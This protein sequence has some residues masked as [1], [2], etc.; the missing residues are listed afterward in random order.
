MDANIFR[1]RLEFLVR[2]KYPVL[3]LNE[4]VERLRLNTLPD[5]A[6]VIT[7]DDGFYSTWKLAIPILNKM[8]LP[9]TIYV[10]TYYCEKRM[11]VFRLVIQYMFWKTNAPSLNVT[12]LG[13][14]KH[15]ECELS[16]YD[17][18]QDVMWSIITFGENHMDAE[19]Q[20]TLCREIGRQLGIDYDEIVERRLFSVMTC[21]ELSEA[22]QMGVDIQLHT[23]RHR[24]PDN[25]E[26]IIKELG[27][28][29]R[30]LE[31]VAGRRLRHFCYPSGI[32][33][34]TQF[35][36]LEEADVISATTCELGLN[37]PGTSLL[38]LR[39]I[40]DANNIADVDFEAEMSGFKDVLRFLMR[41]VSITTASR[42]CGALS[43]FVYPEHK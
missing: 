25:R 2:N 16:E 23:H 20:A 28:N 32:Y 8:R 21:E 38:K 7:F 30:V 34:S 43:S 15:G 17:A 24:L 4:A 14:I 18:V 29:R 9:G 19:G 33:R 3:A 39:R 42:I 35:V 12:H 26:Q 11:P 5:Y 6:T 10:T 31:P 1:K 37:Y 41:C 36:H 40:M 27:D 22:I 13:F